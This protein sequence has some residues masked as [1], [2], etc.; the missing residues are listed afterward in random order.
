MSP[1]QQ[2]AALEEDIQLCREHIAE[3]QEAIRFEKLMGNEIK[4]RMWEARRQSWVERAVVTICDLAHLDV[5]GDL[6]EEEA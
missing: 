5:G 3:A 2:A 6:L 4:W 1:K